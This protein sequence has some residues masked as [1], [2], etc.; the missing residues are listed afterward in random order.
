MSREQERSIFFVPSASEQGMHVTLED[1]EVVRHEVYFEESVTTVRDRPLFVGDRFSQKRIF[2]FSALMIISLA[3]L[4]GRA[5]WMQIVQAESYS[6]QADANRLRKTPIWP[7]RG[8]IRDRQGIVLADNVPRFQVTMTPGRLPSGEEERLLLLGRA[9]RLLGLSVRELTDAADVTGFARDEASLVA[10]DLSYPQAMNVAVALPSLPGFAL[11]VRPKRRYPLSAEIPSIS[12]VIGY[13]GKLSPEEY[14]LRRQS[15]YRRA[16]EIGKTGVERTY[17]TDLRGTIGEQISEVDA[18]G[19]HQANVRAAPSVDGQELHLTID[20]R[21]QRI[22]EQAFAE[23]ASH[24]N[25]TRGAVIALDPRNGELLVA[26]S[27]PGYDDNVFSGGVSSTVYQ[28]LTTKK[29][30]PLFPRA[31]AGAYPSGSTVK[32]VISAAALAEGVVKPGTHVLSVGGIR[33]GSW[34]FPDWKAGG[35]GSTDVRHAIAWSV[36]TF[37]YYV[38]GGYESFLGL[39]SDRLASWMKKFGLGERTGI[40]LPGEATGFVPTRTWKESTTGE[41]WYVGDTYN[42]SIGQGD[43]LVTPLQVAAY[44]S[45]IANGG[46]LVTPHVLREAGNADS[47]EFQAKPFPFRSETIVDDATL[48]VVRAGMRDAVTFGSARALSILSFP[49]AG[50]TGTAQWSSTGNTHAWFTGFAPYD[51]PEI[52]I[53]VL[54]EEGG[55]GS[56]YAVPVARKVLEAWWS[57]RAERGGSF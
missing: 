36:N 31:W 11:E 26:A 29:D 49:V 44:T 10:Q 40:D 22:A 8:M 32:I 50:K 42:L 13:V 39:G 46:A 33:I 53:T 38:G 35:H 52:V 3:L 27:F 24:A 19:R 37:F 7:R 28:A 20:A 23:Q 2:L 21:L 18:L 9:A 45:A 56:S 4:I 25:T 17:E 34:F 14:E 5:A 41:K 16:D 48:A 57:M 12:H 1:P 15:G 47:G 6:L 30:Q 43:L 55:E 51:H 54:L